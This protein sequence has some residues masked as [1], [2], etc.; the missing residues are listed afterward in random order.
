L[1]TGCGALLFLIDRFSPVSQVCAIVAFDAAPLKTQATDHQRVLP[2][3]PS[4]DQIPTL[5]TLFLHVKI[6][7]NSKKDTWQRHMKKKDSLNAAVIKTVR[8]LPKART[9]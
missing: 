7:T 6:R 9:C 3:G 8:S 5:N 1:K 2:C 4:L